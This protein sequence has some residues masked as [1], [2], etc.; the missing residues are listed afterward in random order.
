MSTILKLTKGL[1]VNRP[2][3]LLSQLTCDN[4][5]GNEH[6]VYG[7]IGGPITF[8]NNTDVA[9]KAKGATN[10]PVS[11]SGQVMTANGDG[12]FSYK[13]PASVTPGANTITDEQLVDE[14]GIK[15]AV[16]LNAASLADNAKKIET[17]NFKSNINKFGIKSNPFINFRKALIK[18]I[19]VE[20]VYWGDSISTGGDK[21][22]V[23]SSLIS[24]T[25]SSP[26]AILNGEGYTH[27]IT[28]EIA[29]ALPNSIF[30]FY[31]RAIGGCV[32]DEWEV[33]KTINGITKTW[34]EHI[35]DTNADLLFI[36]FGMNHNSY[37][38]TTTFAR[39][40]DRIYKYMQ[41]NF[42][43]I[44]DIVLVTCPTCVYIE[45]NTSWST[46]LEQETRRNTGK[47]AR[48]F[49]SLYADYILDVSR[50]SDIA[51]F[52]KDLENIYF[53]EKT[54]FN[55]TG[56]T[57]LKNVNDIFAITE[58]CRDFAVKFTMSATNVADG[59]YFAI[60]FNEIV[61]G[62]ELKNTICIFANLEGHGAVKSYGHINDN[63]HFSTFE[64][65]TTSVYNFA[66]IQSVLN[67]R[68]EKKGKTIKIFTIDN[69]TGIETLIIYDNHFDI[70]NILGE[71]HFIK[72]G[73]SIS[74]INITNIR[75]FEA[76][77]VEY[78]KFMTEE[79]MFGKYI[80]GDTNVKAITG[81]NG[82]NHPSS[83]GIAQIYGVPIYEMLSDIMV[84]TKQNSDI[85]LEL[86]KK[87][88][89]FTVDASSFPAYCFGTITGMLFLQGDM[90]TGVDTI[91]FTKNKR[92]TDFE[93]R[94]LLLEREYGIYKVG[95]VTQIVFKNTVASPFKFNT[96]Q[97]S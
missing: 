22:N 4:D 33:N 85:D 70:N 2:A 14:G 87:D 63:A 32:I 80:E 10:E 11:T 51:R 69:A 67:F 43:K 34:I 36:G 68:I 91:P 50:F 76:K 82:V 30:D 37:A 18:N 90:Y 42:T 20:V 86:I 24:G 13:T 52:G 59:E 48:Y 95:S 23:N 88:I 81:G 25:E 94:T 74:T 49:G 38:L 21:L 31:N 89:P 92:V 35:K 57:T 46:E 93:K 78:Q 41:L 72:Q 60:H 96:Y 75:Y 45:G 39:N 65:A 66:S 15:A 56:S 84:L 9:A 19:N 1:K 47:T 44:P 53:E 73:G 61:L 3:I 6:L 7:A 71:I 79:L 62:F 64:M 8:P 27:I 5:A 26:T 58:R 16:A 17:Q 77:G 40:I 55:Q 28:N 54:G 12:T 97:F 29:K 83:R